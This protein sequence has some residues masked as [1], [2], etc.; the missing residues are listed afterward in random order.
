M[1]PLT[2]GK[3]ISG[4][5]SLGKLIEAAQQT[6]SAHDPADAAVLTH[7]L[8]RTASVAIPEAA[9]LDDALQVAMTVIPIMV[10]MRLRGPDPEPPTKGP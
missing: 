6:L 9:E 1:N 10:N 7:E 8:L 5:S 2:I 3:A 4:L